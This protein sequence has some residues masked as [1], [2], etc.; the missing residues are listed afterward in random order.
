MLW[1]L[2]MSEMSQDFDEALVWDSAAITRNVRAVI[3][4]EQSGGMVQS[5]LF[6]RPFA[7]RK[8]FIKDIVDL[9]RAIPDTMRSW[10]LWVCGQGRSHGF[11][12]DP[13]VRYIPVS[14]LPA[15]I[16]DF[17]MATDKSSTGSQSGH[18]VVEKLSSESTLRPLRAPSLD[19]QLGRDIV[20]AVDSADLLD[21][22]LLP[23]E[24]PSFLSTI[25]SS[26]NSLE[27]GFD[28]NFLWKIGPDRLQR[29]PF[30]GFVL[31]HCEHGV[32]IKKEMELA[33]K[34]ALHGTFHGPPACVHLRL[35][36]EKMRLTYR[37]SSLQIPRT[38]TAHKAEAVFI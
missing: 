32:H 27:F 22:T 7:L 9:M 15:T 3:L 34:S 12:M 37:R 20:V 1:L 11:A 26:H 17:I 2:P 8:D 13:A 31:G 21:R 6:F 10:L 19:G 35:Y 23:L 25:P 14:V 24:S 16:L 33:L 29:H 28:L 4:V 5:A 30:L 18:S 38:R 36:R